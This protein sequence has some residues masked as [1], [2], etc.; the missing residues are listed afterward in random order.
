MLVL[1]Q[2]RLVARAHPFDFDYIIDSFASHYQSSAGN[3]TRGS[4]FAIAQS[5]AM[6]I[7]PN[8]SFLVLYLGHSRLPFSG[9]LVSP[10]ITTTRK[11]RRQQRFE[12][13]D[14]WYENDHLLS[15]HILMFPEWTTFIHVRV[16]RERR[17]VGAILL[18]HLIF[19]YKY[20]PCLWTDSDTEHDSFVVNLCRV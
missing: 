8:Y 11:N 6:G 4:P 2:V 13:E 5:V 18:L 17:K 16:R 20:I 3:I 15:C 7:R 9:F 19:L 12:Y 14:C 1:Q 10:K